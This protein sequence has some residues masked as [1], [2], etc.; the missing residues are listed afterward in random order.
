[1]NKHVKISACVITKDEEGTIQRWLDGMKRVAD[2]IVVVDTGS[3]D[4]T[5]EI[6]RENG[7]EPYHFFWT[8]DFAEAKNYAIDRATGD[9]IVF[10]DADEYFA[11]GDL[12]KIR[13][14]VEECVKRRP[15]TVAIQNP[16]LN[17]DADNEGRI[18]SQAVMVR[19][20][21]R[22]PEIRYEGW[23]HERLTLNKPGWTV[24]SL[25][26]VVIYHTGYSAS[27]VKGKLS[28]NLALL[29]QYAAEHGE[30]PDDAIFF[31]D[32]YW[33]LGDKEKVLEYALKAVFNPNR[34][35][36]LGG[37]ESRLLIAALNQLGHPVHEIEAAIQ[38]AVDT[39]PEIAE[40]RLIQGSMY[41]HLRRY[42]EAE[43]SF[44]QGFQIYE[45]RD[46]LQVNEKG[47]TDQTHVVWPEA[48]Y[49]AAKL[50]MMQFD[51]RGA[52]EYL[53]KGLQANPMERGLLRLWWQIHMRDSGSKLLQQLKQWYDPRYHA[54]F[55]LYT[56]GNLPPEVC[57][58]YA[59]FLKNR[60]SLEGK[61]YENPAEAV[62]MLREEVNENCALAVWT[63]L[64][65]GELQ[66]QMA[67]V[68]LP[69]EWQKLF[70]DLREGKEPQAGREVEVMKKFMKT[71]N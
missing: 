29:K 26:E 67:E 23:I 51:V 49:S 37:E 62:S 64:E 65:M 50:R 70:H 54:D 10:L 19:V 20:F 68:L 53:K 15:D 69:E 41:F 45:N 60:D 56:I 32:C 38:D 8:D 35:K 57:A 1:M 43:E 40:F 6:V 24:A 71:L 44:K 39:Y 63:M 59:P 25:N 30:N 22:M 48:C 14:A 16:L 11:A 66:T 46:R 12:P 7:I 13:M 18:L 5:V 34:R 17:I 58:A 61:I 2:E 9:W 33:G 42:T 4:R 36:R 31:A 55:L 52:D 28:R 47:L 27:I 3:T 21:R